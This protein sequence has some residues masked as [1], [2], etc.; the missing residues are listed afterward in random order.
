MD[1]TVLT[2][3]SYVDESMTTGEPVPVEKTEGA[4][5]VGAT[6]NGSGALTYRATKVGAD[7][8]LAQIIAMVEQAQGAKLPIQGMVD[9]ITAWFVPEVMAAAA[10][11]VLVWLAFGQDPAFEPALAE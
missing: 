6:V 7:T 3:R 8:M 11:T 4:D 10:L 9:L 1:G 2:G 5:V